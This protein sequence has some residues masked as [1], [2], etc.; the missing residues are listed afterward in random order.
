[1]PR[2][3]YWLFAP[4]LSLVLYWPGL[5]C[6]FQKDDFAWLGLHGMIHGWRDVP[7]VLFKPFAQGTV[8]TLSERVFYTSFH[9]MFGMNPL[10]YRCWA[11][12]TFF[13]AL[14]LLTIVTTRLTGSRAAG[15][16]AGL[17][18]AVNSAMAIA[19][20]W[21][22][23][24]YEL[25]CSLFF[26][27]GLW[28]L[29][30]HGETGERRFAIAHWIVYLLG[31]S[32]LELNV[33][34][35]ALACVYALCRAPRL[36]RS[37]LPMWVPAAIYTVAHTMAAPLP[38]SGP[39]KMYWDARVFSTLWTYW[40][41]ALGPSRLILLRIYPSPGRSALTIL[42]TAGLVWFL[43]VQLRKKQWIVLLFPAWFVIVLAPLLPLRDHRMDYYL[44][45][46]VLGLAMWGAWAIDAGW[47]A[48][49][50]ARVSA[51]SLAAVYL[52]VAIPLARAGVV[53]FYDRGELI[54]ATVSGLVEESRKQPGKLILLQGVDSDMFWSAIFHRPLRLYGIDD[55]YLTAE[56]RAGI[57]GDRAFFLDP[58][59]ARES[60]DSGRAVV[61]D[62]TG[63][64]VREITAQYRSALDFQQ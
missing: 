64:H 27:A 34:Y 58:A 32:V 11:F 56:S 49:A 37:I 20:S 31:F 54:K 9:A 8:R 12:L 21:T 18:W 50:W 2:I 23:I 22:A 48:G 14:A 61:F 25:L 53:S 40:K 33:V 45:I 62:V 43:V 10:P 57:D 28:L 4:L 59:A 19:L 15:F 29:I 36:L 63:G 13:A 24:Y 42:L 7:M 39:Y 46:P 26:L 1:M 38:S 17:L 47:R 6:W 60:L 35:P 41:W 16:W 51:V 52:C 55:V 30:R 5:V 44:T 3:A